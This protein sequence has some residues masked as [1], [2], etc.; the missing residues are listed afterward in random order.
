MS[1]PLRPCTVDDARW[2]YKHGFPIACL[3][4]QTY[5]GLDEVIKFPEAF[6]KHNDMFVLDGMEQGKYPGT[7]A[8]WLAES[9]DGP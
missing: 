8:N 6:I 5:G 7:T 2:Y 1:I 3:T 9:I 4:P